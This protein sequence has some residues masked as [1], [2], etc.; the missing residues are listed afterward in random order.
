MGFGPG[1][2]SSTHPTGT[3]SRASRLRS[4]P[5]NATEGVPGCSSARSSSIRLKMASTVASQSSRV[6]RSSTGMRVRIGFPVL[7]VIWA[8]CRPARPRPHLRS[9]RAAHRGGWVRPGAEESG[10]SNRTGGLLSVAW[11]VGETASYSGA[12]TPIAGCCR[13][14]NVVNREIDSGNATYDHV[15]SRPGQRPHSESD[16]D[17]L[18]P[19][20]VRVLANGFARLA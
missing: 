13:E 16:V 15:S 17:E 3:G 7:E 9:C 20:A 8:S 19:P 1:T 11:S 18:T 4:L 12:R 14:V 5:G 10:G 6:G 2:V